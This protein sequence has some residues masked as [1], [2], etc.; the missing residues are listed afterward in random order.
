LASTFFL[1]HYEASP[2]AEKIRLMFGAAGQPWGSVLTT[3]YP[4]RPD[5]DVLA[6]G[7]RRIPVAQIGADIFCDTALIAGEVATLTGQQQ[8]APVIDDAAASALAARAEGAVFFAAITSASPL[9]LLG[10]L[11]ASNGVI[12]TYKFVRDRRGMMKDAAVKPPEGAAAAQVFDAY[13]ADLDQHLADHEWLAGE[14]ASYADFCAYHPIWLALSVGRVN[15][16]ERY[17]HVQRW[18]KDMAHLGHGE[19]EEFSAQEALA[20]ARAARPRELPESSEGAAEARS[21]LGNPVSIAPA[22]YGRAGVEGTLVAVTA[23]RYILARET[24]QLGSVHVHFPHEGYE[25][26]SEG[27]LSGTRPPSVHREGISSR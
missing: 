11:L 18:I 15:V 14:Q 6:G 1:H 10:K 24:E 27:D 25:L 19:R 4:P 16:L 7:Y 8:L 23:E 20:Q 2:Y 21:A 9:R 17:A 12:G 5:I 13:I 26:R 22:D 3:P